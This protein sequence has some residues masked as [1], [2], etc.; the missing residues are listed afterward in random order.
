ND[1][2]EAFSHLAKQY[3]GIVRFHGLLN[4]PYLLITDPKLVQMILS[5]PYDF[6][7]FRINTAIFKELIGEGI[8]LAEGNSHKRQRK[9]MSPSFSFANVKEMIPTF[10]QAGHNLKAIWMKEIG[11]KREERITITAIISKITL[12]V[13]GLHRLNPLYMD[14]SNL[15]PFIRKFPTR[16]NNKYYDSIK[17]INNISEKLLADQKNCPVQGTDLLSLLV[18]SNDQLPVAEQLTHYELVSQV[19]TFILAGHETT[20]V[21]LSWTLYFLAANPDIQ[22]RLRKEILA[23]LPDRDCH[24]TFDQIEQLKFLECVFKE[25]LRIIPPEFKSIL[26]VII[27]NL[28]FKLVE[29]FT[30]EKKYGG[31]IKPNPGIDLLVSSVDC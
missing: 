24:P 31:T 26:A 30:F 17:T 19:K 28:E 29:G 25:V 10:V 20:S 8:T 14:L 9:M 15:L 11:N 22:Y 16:D 2:G 5:R 4:K 3:G 6:P 18:K 27:R 7:K 13:I 23:I 12:D 1:L 21:A